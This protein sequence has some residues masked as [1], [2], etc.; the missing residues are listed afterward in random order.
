[1]TYSIVAMYCQILN[2]VSFRLAQVKYYLVSSITSS[3]TVRRIALS[4][5]VPTTGH[6]LTD[7]IFV[8]LSAG[9]IRTTYFHAHSDA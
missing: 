9:P 6:V 3:N 5:M 2:T 8:I 4:Y 7:T 1:M